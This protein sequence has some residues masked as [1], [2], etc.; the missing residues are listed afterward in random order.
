MIMLRMHFS[1]L[2]RSHV[3]LAR[4]GTLMT[5]H[6]RVRTP[7]FMPIAT[8]AAIKTLQVSEVKE[9][10]AE[11]ILSNTYHNLVQPGLVVIKKFGGLHEFMKSDLPILTDSGGFQIFSLA[12]L[13][14]IDADGVTFQSHVDGRTLRITPEESIRI[15]VA[16]GSDIMMAFDHFPGYPATRKQ[17]EYAV[18]LTTEWAKRCIAEKK[19]IEQKNKKA[20]KQLLFGIIQGSVFRDLR[21][22]SVRELTALPFNGF[23]VGGL[24]VGE[25]SKE[26]YKVLDYTVPLLPENKPRYLMGVGYPD[27][28]VEAVRRGIDM[29]DCVIPTREGRHGRLFVWKKGKA[30]KRL[31]KGFYETINI[32]NSRF[33][34]DTTPIND[35]SLKQYSRAYLHH[36]F[37][38]GEPLGQR[39]GTINNLE[40]YLQLMIAIKD[41]R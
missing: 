30:G 32:R 1:L 38:T 40:F 25:P 24:A 31:G 2:R 11:I 7:F 34:S 6:G 28:I 35:G 5:P 3:S 10:G 27:N 26:M 17:A 37:K 9:L 39:F 41:S 21:E 36:L 22:K 33:Q 14:K 29:F 18:E 12:K 13:R 16:L 8:K 15:Q 19:R 23:A 4:I 20:K